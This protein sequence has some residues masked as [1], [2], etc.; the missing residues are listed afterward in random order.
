MGLV[1]GDSGE[2][3]VVGLRRLIGTTAALLVFGATAALWVASVR[4]VYAIGQIT[5]WSDFW[6]HPGSS[7][8]TSLELLTVVSSVLGGLCI[9][10]AWAIVI[11]SWLVP[12]RVEAPGR[13]TIGFQSCVALILGVALAGFDQWPF[14]I[15]DNRATLGLIFEL[16]LTAVPGYL[17]IGVRL[18]S[19]LGGVRETPVDLRDRIGRLLGLGAIIQIPLWYLQAFLEPLT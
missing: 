17:V 9:G 15:A 14:A 6:R 11:T 7:M 13:R 4:E 12:M 18:A 2:S 8:A 1:M 19:I 3:S 5:N 10:G 16:W